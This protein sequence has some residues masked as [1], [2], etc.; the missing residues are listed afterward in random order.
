MSCEAYLVVGIVAVCNVEAVE[1]IDGFTCI[2]KGGVVVAGNVAHVDGVG[3][4]CYVAGI[5]FHC[6]GK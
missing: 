4:G 6:G 1:G 2:V 5:G 3:E